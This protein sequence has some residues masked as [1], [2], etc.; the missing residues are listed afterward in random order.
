VAFAPENLFNVV[1]VEPEIPNNTGSIGR[2]CVATGC[3]LHL[4]EPM[5]FVISDKQLK[6]AGLDYWQYLPCKIHPDYSQFLA[7]QDQ[8]RGHN[9]VRSIYFSSHAK[10]SFYEHQFQRGDY[11]VFGKETQGLNPE[12]I[13]NHPETS[14]HIPTSKNVRSLNLATAVSV[15]IYEGYRQIMTKF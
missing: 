9:A 4:I 1:L 14:Y 7:F 10:K 13:Y 6:R 5:G 11:L 3:A 2:S 12:L 15:V 8:E